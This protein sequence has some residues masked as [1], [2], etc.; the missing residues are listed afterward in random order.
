MKIVICF[1]LALSLN[2]VTSLVNLNPQGKNTIPESKKLQIQI[3]KGNS[4]INITDK[5]MPIMRSRIQRITKLNRTLPLELLTKSSSEPAYAKKNQSVTGMFKESGEVQHYSHQEHSHIPI[6]SYEPLVL[7][8][9]INKSYINTHKTDSYNIVT[10]TKAHS[11]NQYGNDLHTIKND[12]SESLNNNHDGPVYIDPKVAKLIA[13]YLKSIDTN[14]NMPQEDAPD[15]NQLLKDYSNDYEIKELENKLNNLHAEIAELNKEIETLKAEDQ[16]DQVSFI[17]QKEQKLEEEEESLSLDMY[18][19]EDEVIREEIQHL[20]TQEEQMVGQNKNDIELASIETRIGDLE[21]KDALVDEQIKDLEID[22]IETKIKHLVTHDIDHNNLSQNLSDNNDLNQEIQV[23]QTH[24]EQ[25]KADHQIQ[26]ELQS[27]IREIDNRLEEI[28]TEP[29]HVNEI[30]SLLKIKRKLEDTVNEVSSSVSLNQSSIPTF[31][32]TD[33]QSPPSEVGSADAY[34]SNFDGLQTAVVALQYVVKDYI[35]M[36]KDLPATL[37]DIPPIEIDNQDEIN[38]LYGVLNKFISTYNAKRLEMKQNEKSRFGFLYDYINGIKPTAE[39]IIVFFKMVDKINDIKEQALSKD[40][41]YIDKNQELFDQADNIA[42]EVLE[43]Q[44]KSNDLDEKDN[45][46][47]AKVVDIENYTYINN[48]NSNNEVNTKAQITAEA[49][50]I[51]VEFRNNIMSYLGF[52]KESFTAF[53]QWKLSVGTQLNDLELY[54]KEH[55]AA[56][57][58]RLQVRKLISGPITRLNKINIQ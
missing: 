14:K 17:E 47:Y 50:P 29:G 46:I 8:Q 22:Q 42:K 34:N 38:T 18:R 15:I 3:I 5:A 12:L 30:V 49:L 10:T 19:K 20:R 40:Q 53:D 32:D 43:L 56:E 2:L 7:D 24:E 54:V 25:I 13:M 26:D 36:F 55:C 57:A 39:G 51:L 23:L 27:D 52:I 4:G 33:Y 44:A 48:T 6:R 45:E 21:I 11:L 1:V 9:P 37:Q 16:Y 35:E 58:N 28:K 41:T 31:G